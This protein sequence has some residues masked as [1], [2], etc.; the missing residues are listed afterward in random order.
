MGMPGHS[1]IQSN[2][3]AECLTRLASTLPFIVSEP[4]LPVRYAAIKLPLR[5]WAHQ[6]IDV[7]LPLNEVNDGG[8]Y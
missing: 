2:E 7:L 5:D 1:G 8:K 3:L 6:Q 4:V